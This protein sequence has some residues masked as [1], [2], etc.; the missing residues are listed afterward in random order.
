MFS[1]PHLRIE[2]TALAWILVLIPLYMGIIHVSAWDAGV[3]ALIGGAA[4][5]LGDN[6]QFGLR[7]MRVSLA[8]V[9]L[10]TAT[11]AGVGGLIYFLALIFL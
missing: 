3:Y 4:I 6:A 11:V 8:E 9:L 2:I 10:W 7:G 5:A 1:D